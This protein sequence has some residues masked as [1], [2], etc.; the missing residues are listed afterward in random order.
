MT[1]TRAP[2]LLSFKEAVNEATTMAMQR[3]S[4][5][6]VTGLG[7]TDPKRIFGTTNGL[8]EQFGAR[9]VFEFPTS[10]ACM[11]GFAVGAALRGVPSISVHQRSDF[12][13]LAMDQLV[14]AAAK[15][16]F[17]FGGQH[18][19]PLVVRLICGRGWGQGPTHSQN[20]HSWFAH[21][22]GLRV[23]EPST[24][25]DAK[26]L[27]LSALN[28]INPVIFIEHRWLHDTLG[29]VQEGY[30]T[31]PI[32]RAKILRQGKDVTIVAMSY[33]VPEAIKA[34]SLLEGMDINAEVIDLR[35]LRPL[36]VAC[37]RGSLK[38][39]GRLVV[40]EPNLP[41][42]SV[43]SEIIARSVS[44]GQIHFHAPPVLVS[45][46]DFSEPTSF[47]LTKGYHPKAADIVDVVCSWFGKSISHHE[48]LSLPHDVPNAF[49][50]GPF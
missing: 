18:T 32:G 35:S 5:L 21:I 40:I 29:E 10:E 43:G 4:N 19:V 23:L 36:D 15:W 16:R 49:F 30:F 47:G 28:E 38:K 22:P 34:G 6:I 25:A 44:V 48:S 1:E 9:R 45:A 24:P 39:T 50:R 20:F 2:R 11:M 41:V 8:L 13:L 42:C 14:N 17:M 12:F 27:M 37:I 3:N 46:P 26:G 7:V 33:G 31:E